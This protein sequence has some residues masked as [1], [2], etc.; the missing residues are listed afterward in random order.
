MR[1]SSILPLLTCELALSFV[2][3]PFAAG[4][5]FSNNPIYGPTPPEVAPS[6]PATAYALSGIDSVDMFNGHMRLALP[7]HSIGGRGESGY[8][9]TISA[10]N[11]G[12][13]DFPLKVAALA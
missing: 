6:S 8:T 9:I 7:I 13:S 10:S 11:P 3:A 2:L 1:A 4:Q 12:L 5:A